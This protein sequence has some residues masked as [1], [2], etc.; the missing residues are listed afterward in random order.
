[1]ELFPPLCRNVID[2][3]NP[4]KILYPLTSLL[5]AGVLM[6][7]CRLGSRRQIA[8]LLR[9]SRGRKTFAAIFGIHRFPHGDT[10]EEVVRRL[11]PDQLQNVVTSMTESL[12]RKKVLYPYRLRSRYFVVAIDGTGIH[13]FSERHC[14]HC[15]TVTHKGKTSYY[16][17]VLEAK[18]VTPNGFAFSLMSEF[19][20]N[21][22]PNMTKQDCE[23]KAFYRM[24][25]GLKARF[26]RLP[27]L[28]SLDGLFA[29]GPVFGMCSDY[30]WKYMITLK[31]DDLPS[32]NQEFRALSP[33]QPE[34]RFT[35]HT[36]IQA[37]IT[38]RFRWV[39]HIAYVDTKSREHTL[40]VLQCVETKPCQEGH[41][42]TN[43]FRWVTN[44]HLAAKNAVEL[45]CNGGR[46]RWKVENEGF[47]VQKNGGYE[48]EHG[49]STDLTA[50]KAYYF[51]LQI[52][53]I[54]AQLL[55][56]GSL[57]KEVFPKGVGS[58]KNLAFLLLEAW[59]NSPLSPDAY[60]A[61]VT[62][63]FQIRFDTS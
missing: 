55:Y 63:R 35:W 41:P 10:L 29:C 54:L 33:L 56:K 11:D 58:S 26:P 57:L 28:L 45:A 51:L 1:M 25:P 46:I 24:A 47:N 40:S 30:G 31:D 15:L 7:L 3:R 8:F 38:Q 9:N 53:H 20:E 37:E 48:L 62:T 16:H 36:G 52:A 23:L 4:R 22:E 43:T 27:L 17:N 49:Y 44:C 60:Q 21:P 18:L 12:I 2:P 32:V 14:E 50:S 39:D 61:L 34:N 13:T 5:F 6:F 19:I 42:S 59:R